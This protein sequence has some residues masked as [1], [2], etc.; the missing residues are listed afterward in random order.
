MIQVVVAE[1]KHPI[2]RSIV[3]KIEGFAP[4]VVV[5]GEA[6]DGLSALAMCRRVRPQIVFTDIRMPGMDGL[7]LISELKEILPGTVFV[8]ISGY[9]E[10]EYAREAIRLGANDFL[11]KPVTQPAIDAILS[12]VV[13]KLRAA[14]IESERRR[15]GD[16]LRGRPARQAAAYDHQRQWSLMV[17]CAGSLSRLLPRSSKSGSATQPDRG[18]E[19]L[20]DLD[21]L[22]ARLLAGNVAAR[23][24]DGEG[25]DETIIVFGSTTGDPIPY[26]SVYEALLSRYE[27]TACRLAVSVHPRVEYPEALRS[28]YLSA[29][30]ALDRHAEFGRSSL[31]IL[32]EDTSP[33]ASLAPYKIYDKHKLAAYLK[34]GRKD[35][36]MQA[37]EDCLRRCETQR[38]TQSMVE[39]SLSRLA[40]DVRQTAPAE[41][42]ADA[43]LKWELDEIFASSVDYPSLFRH[44]TALFENFFPSASD[45]ALSD[46]S[47]GQLIDKAEAYFINHLSEEITVADAADFVNL[48]VSFLSREFKKAKGLSPIEYLTQLRIDLAKRLIEDPSDL[49]FREIAAMAGY[50]NQY[51]FSKVFK[52]AT[53][54]TPTEFKSLRIGRSPAEAIQDDT[55]K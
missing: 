23:A 52:Q 30:A 35:A 8:I 6:A 15:W 53:G 11:L 40:Y 51:Y 14:H 7:R 17:V 22:L 50:P 36:F 18:Q 2:L 9:G 28:A 33:Y 24:L 19:E 47:I 26:R 25:M 16:L 49:K 4:D 46:G 29:R 31:I 5:A 1:D 34:S 27:G 55:K 21:A 48:N 41:G 20:D 42:I 13:P 3:R 43:E 12:K 44:L 54:L 32:D 39:A 38:Y 10:F 45:A 37:V